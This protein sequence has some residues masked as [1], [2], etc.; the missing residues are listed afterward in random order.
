MIYVSYFNNP[1]LRDVSQDKIMSVA[2]SKK[3]GTQ[4][5]QACELL[6]PSNLF[7]RYMAK[8]LS[9]TDFI[10]EYWETVL[11]KLSVTDIYNKYDGMILC[12]HEKNVTTCHRFAIL[13]WFKSYGLEV[14]EFERD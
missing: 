4:F 8:E 5:A 1:K 11:D 12:C 9:Y 3:Y 2:L 14:E 6:V 7:K 13:E 10:S